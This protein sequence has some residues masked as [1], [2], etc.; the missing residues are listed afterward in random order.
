METLNNSYL[1][2]CKFVIP[3]EKI[4]C[5]NSVAG[6]VLLF[7]VRE[8]LLSDFLPQTDYL[9]GDLLYF[10]LLLLDTCLYYPSN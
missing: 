3:V 9:D 5:C 8:V 7:Y 6:I 10:S 4:K 1:G 2:N